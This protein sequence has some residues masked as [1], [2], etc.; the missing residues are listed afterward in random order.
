MI[1]NQSSCY[2]I[3]LDEFSQI[4]LNL[5]SDINSSY[6]IKEESLIYVSGKIMLKTVE[7]FPKV[8]FVFRINSS[9]NVDSN[10]EFE[11]KLETVEIQL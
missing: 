7:G 9:Q 5:D 10:I 8:R 1:E 2:E 4:F 6:I 3:S 11:V